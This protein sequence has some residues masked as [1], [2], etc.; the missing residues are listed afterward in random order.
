M[1]FKH[2][3]SLGQNFLTD[4]N[5]L[6]AIV[7]DAGVTA[8]DNIIEVG[9]GQGALTRPLA[10]SGANVLSFEIDNRL[11][12]YLEP[13]MAE[14]NNLRVVFGDFM[15][16]DLPDI[17]YKAVANLPYYITTPVLFRFLDDPNC[18]SVTVM[19]QKEVAERIIAKEGGKDYGILSVST[20]LIG[21]PKITRIVGRQLF[22]PPPNVDS[23][24]VTI[25]KSDSASIYDDN[26]KNLVK[27]AF[28]MRRKTLMNCLTSAGY[29]KA[30]ISEALSE[31]GLNQAVRGEKLTPK[32]FI[33]LSKLLRS[34]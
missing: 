28:S 9:A 2:S 32:Q 15:K 30:A 27:A 21:S 31:M 12:E 20:Q 34:K 10:E 33:E 3:H 6:S 25:V 17:K 4:K 5:L 7:K 29:N 16:E 23:A 26:L 8:E 14:Y 1:T 18:Q 19:V 24:V 22:T 11:K 13:L